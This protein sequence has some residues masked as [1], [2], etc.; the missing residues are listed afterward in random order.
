MGDTYDA[1]GILEFVQEVKDMHPG[2]FVHSIYLKEDSGEDRKAGYVSTFS[3]RLMLQTLM[4]VKFGNVNEQVEFVAEQLNN[5]TELQYG[6]DAMG[7][8]QGEP[9]SLYAHG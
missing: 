7:F 9:F 4:S 8:S 2:I 5:I 6:F 1:P 3:L